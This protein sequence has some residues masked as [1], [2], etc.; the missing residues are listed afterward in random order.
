MRTVEYAVLLTAAVA[1]AFAYRLPA[2]CGTPNKGARGFR[3]MPAQSADP[4]FPE[5]VVFIV[6]GDTGRDVPGSLI[7]YGQPGS[8]ESTG[9]SV[10]FLE[11]DYVVTAD[12]RRSRSRPGSA[13]GSTLRRARRCCTGT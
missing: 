12:E 3:E 6:V 4:A 2:F 8:F 1:L 5:G 7:V 10:I 9:P 11:A 13:G